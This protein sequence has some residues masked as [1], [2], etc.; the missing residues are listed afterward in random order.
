M[1]TLKEFKIMKKNAVI[2]NTARGN[3]INEKDLKEAIEANIIRG[4][5]LDVF[6]VEPA[7]DNI[8]F[9]TKNIILTPHIAA[10]TIEAQIIVAE[11]IALQIS[12]YFNNNEVI[13]S[14]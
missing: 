9:T 12:N 14:I 8:L 11:Q 2:I 10:S 5:A 7:K 13:N 4:A 6:S 1:L 3:L